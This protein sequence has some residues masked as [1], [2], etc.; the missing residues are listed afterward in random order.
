MS[1]KAYNVT[2]TQLNTATKSTTASGASMIKFRASLTVRG[3]K[4]ERTVVAMGKAADAIRA[5]VRKGSEFAVRAIFDRAPAN[6]DGERGGEFL[7]VVGVPQAKA[8]AA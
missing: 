2:V 3:R 8:A 1:Q 7:S 5:N 6:E 4:V